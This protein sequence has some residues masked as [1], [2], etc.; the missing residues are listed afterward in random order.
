MKTHKVKSKHFNENM[1]SVNNFLFKHSTVNLVKIIWKLPFP[2]E[3]GLVIG[4]GDPAGYHG[5]SGNPNFGQYYYCGSDFWL[6]VLSVDS[7]VRAVGSLLV[8]N[9]WISEFFGL[10][11]VFQCCFSLVIICWS[12]IV[13]LMKMLSKK[14][15]KIFKK[16]WLTLSF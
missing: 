14:N 16:L 12:F 8:S 4:P 11:L 13:L 10:F 5:P 9:F 1:S 7:L 6:Q 3:L 15:M 2:Q